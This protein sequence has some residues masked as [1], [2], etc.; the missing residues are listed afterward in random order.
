MRDDQTQASEGSAE[1]SLAH[2]AAAPLAL[3]AVHDPR[4]PDVTPVM[5]TAPVCPLFVLSSPPNTQALLP[6]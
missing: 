6:L 2:A 4:P 3:T 5:V 1:R